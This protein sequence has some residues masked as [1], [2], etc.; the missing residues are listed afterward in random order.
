MPSIDLRQA[1]C[2]RARWGVA[3]TSQIHYTESYP[4]RIDWV[5]KP[6]GYLPVSPDCSSF[7]VMCFEWAGAPRPDGQPAGSSIVGD[8][9]TLM[10]FALAQI[11]LD[12]CDAAD[13]VIYGT[14]QLSTQHVAIILGP[15]SNP[16]TV[17]HGDE[18][19]PLFQPVFAETRPKRYFRFVTSVPGPT[20][21]APKPPTPKEKEMECIAIS[22]GTV[23]G[24]WY[25]KGSKRVMVSP[26]QLTTLLALG[27]P[28]KTVTDAEL[29]AFVVTPWG[30]I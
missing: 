14:D 23:K 22:S 21:P 8:T 13:L 15:G 11:T 16:L 7:T 5:G 6:V 27:V 24:D 2:D 9:Q 26:T 10:E 30:Q 19:G 28:K 25:V 3:H 12:E 17:S 1:I 18:A 4:G 29:N 20:P